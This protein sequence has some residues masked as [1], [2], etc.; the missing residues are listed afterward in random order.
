MHVILP[1]LEELTPA[2]LREGRGSS[3]I[4]RNHAINECADRIRRAG[5]TVSHEIPVYV[6]YL[7]DGLRVDSAQCPRVVTTKAK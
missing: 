7:D 4:N 6:M 2:E 5:G 1:H 3:I